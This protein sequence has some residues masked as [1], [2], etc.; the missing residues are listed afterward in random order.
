M[1]SS[2][3]LAEL[4]ADI[5]QNGLVHPIVTCDG[6]ILDGRN[7][8]RAC[9]MANVE[10]RF[11]DFDGDNPYRYAW[12]TNGQRRDIDKLQRAVIKGLL[13]EDALKYEAEKA[14]ESRREK[15]RIDAIERPRGPGRKADEISGSHQ[16]D[17]NLSDSKQGAAAKALARAAEVSTPTAERALSLI[18]ADRDLAERVARGEVKGM[19][20]LR[21]VKRA[22]LIEKVSALPEGKYRVIYADP[23][24]KYGDERVGIEHGGAAAAEYPTMSVTDLCALDVKSLAA[25]NAVLFCWATFPLLPD[26]LEVVRAWGFKYKTAIVW[27]KQR[28]NLGNYHDA[29]AE[30]LLICTR[31][32]GTP[33]VTTRPRQVQAAKSGGHS[34][35]P[36]M[37]RE[38]I[39]SLYKAGP[40]IELFRRGDAPSGWVVWGNESKAA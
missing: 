12:S 36:E 14:R 19:Q 40:R 23:P 25:E 22:Q 1:L 35:K 31:G 5:E 9:K 28:S 21:E 34:E 20:A 29:C 6:M 18:G 16:P 37:F 2:E 33:D 27:D 15:N 38:L 10:P 13:E 30:L 7:R 39:D 17:G 3:R 24:W 26:A 4:V 32:S 11:V 8:F